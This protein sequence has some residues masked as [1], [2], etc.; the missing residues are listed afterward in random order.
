M[1]LLHLF[2][3]KTTL[4][5]EQHQWNKLWELWVEGRV[6]SPYAELMTYQGEINNGGHS[7][8]FINVANT[9][10]LEKELAALAQVLPPALWNNLQKAYEA[11]RILEEDEDDGQAEET[12]ERCDNTFYANEEEINRLLKAHAAKVTL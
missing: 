7:Q 4:T 8:Y 12:L 3:K 6:S 9:G 2:R 5:E 11:H 1:G 10:D